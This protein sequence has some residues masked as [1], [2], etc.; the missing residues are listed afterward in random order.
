MRNR[1][2]N[3]LPDVIY[4]VLAFIILTHVQPINRLYTGLADKSQ[5]WLLAHG[6]LP[7]VKYEW[8]IDPVSF[9]LAVM[10]IIVID[11]LLFTLVRLTRRKLTIYPQ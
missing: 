3:M 7:G 9:W 11:V 4:S 6:L 2:Y 8:N 1:L 10:F 5:H